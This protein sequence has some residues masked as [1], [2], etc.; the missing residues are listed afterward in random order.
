MARKP[1]NAVNRPSQAHLEYITVKGVRK[2]NL[3]YNPAL[4]KTRG[5]AQ[6][7]VKQNTA[8]LPDKPLNFM[9]R[10]RIS[11]RLAEK[12]E[13]DIESVYR[14]PNDEGEYFIEPCPPIYVAS[15]IKNSEDELREAMNGSGKVDK[16]TIRDAY[17][18]RSRELDGWKPAKFEDEYHA[19]QAQN[20]YR[21]MKDM[22][23]TAI[24]VGTGQF[25]G[26][27]APGVTEGQE[28]IMYE[29]L[30]R[31]AVYDMLSAGKYD[32]DNNQ[33]PTDEAIDKMPVTKAMN[34]EGVRKL[35]AD[36]YNERTNFNHADNGTFFP[37]NLAGYNLGKQN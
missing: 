7:A 24:R 37:F 22:Q 13:M 32:N 30:T 11:R 34:R 10:D 2:R 14:Q 35:F 26:E 1:K 29:E 18:R 5:K 3:A 6:N 20:L 28:R 15:E 17:Y 25:G 36:M 16:E 33:H 8:G 19:M 31:Y 12:S 23:K 27:R 4:K 9:A 21:S